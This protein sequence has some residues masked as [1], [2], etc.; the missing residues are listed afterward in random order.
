MESQRSGPQ[1]SEPWAKIK[2]DRHG[3][4]TI[5]TFSR[6]RKGKSLF[7]AKVMLQMTAKSKITM[8]ATGENLRELE[9]SIREHYIFYR[10]GRM[11]V[12]RR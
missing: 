5:E 11:R 10:I 9:D 8:V 12:N 1:A 7:L 6:R 3:D 4:L 2:E